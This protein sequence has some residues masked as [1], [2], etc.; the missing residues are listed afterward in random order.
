MK[1]INF[2][3]EKSRTL[4]TKIAKSREIIVFSQ[5]VEL[6]INSAIVDY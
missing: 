3:E 6:P 1:K 5:N 2:Q 4:N